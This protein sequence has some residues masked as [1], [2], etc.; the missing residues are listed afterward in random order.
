MVTNF[1]DVCHVKV[2][3]NSIHR[4]AADALMKLC[5]AAFIVAK[6]GVFEMRMGARLCSLRSTHLPRLNVAQRRHAGGPPPESEVLSEALRTAPPRYA[7][8]L[9][10]LSEKG[11]K[12]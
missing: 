9:T 2:L 1:L 5:L 3:D 6:L 12:T 7:T 4:G 10:R 8:V 11:H